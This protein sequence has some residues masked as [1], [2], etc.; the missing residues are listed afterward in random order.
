MPRALSPHP[1]AYLRMTSPD[2]HAAAR[3]ALKDDEPFHDPILSQTLE[4]FCI[5]ATHRLGEVSFGSAVPVTPEILDQKRMVEGACLGFDRL[6]RNAITLMIDE[7]RQTVATHGPAWVA[8]ADRGRRRGQELHKFIEAP[9]WWRRDPELDG[10]TRNAL[11]ICRVRRKQVREFDGGEVRRKGIGAPVAPCRPNFVGDPGH[12]TARGLWRRA[13]RGRGRSRKHC[14][15]GARDLRE[16]GVIPWRH[17]RVSLDR[18]FEC[19]L[20]V[21]HYWLAS[22]SPQESMGRAMTPDSRALGSRPTVDARL[23]EQPRLG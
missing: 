19:G 7:R 8:N 20:W 12:R 18:P 17:C 10:A 21:K 22:G 3:T 23:H 1:K 6:E 2:V 14:S 4:G 9:W 16:H 11:E 15:E 13:C 5:P